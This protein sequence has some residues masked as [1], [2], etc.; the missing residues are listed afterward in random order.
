M[1]KASE[2]RMGNI[3]EDPSEDFGRVYSLSSG[4]SIELAYNDSEKPHGQYRLAEVS[5][6]ALSYRLLRQ[7]GFVR[8]EGKK[9]YEW[10]K[11]CCK[12]VDAG[13]YF[14]TG[15]DLSKKIHYLHQLQNLI[16]DLT[17]EELTITL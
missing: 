12:L 2:L 17:G 10:I 7:S 15:V 4:D 1:I 3:L 11:G 13:Y 16:F 6:I 8:G 5:A 14:I 9:E